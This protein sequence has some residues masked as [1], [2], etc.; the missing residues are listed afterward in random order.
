MSAETPK[1]LADVKAFGYRVA[2]ERRDSAPEAPPAFFVIGAPRSGSTSLCSTLKR[3]PRISFSFPKETH[4]LHRSRGMRSLAQWRSEYLDRYHGT[5]GPQHQAVGDGSVSYLYALETVERAME[6]D[7]RARFLMVLRNPVDMIQSWHLRLL[8]LLDE[9]EESFE[10]AWALQERRRQ[11]LDVPP[12]CRDP[13]ILQYGEIGCHALHVQRV[14]ELVGRE[15]C[16]VLLFDDLTSDPGATYRRTLAFLGVDDDGQTEFR[17]KRETMAF[18]STT[19]QRLVMNPPGWILRMIQSAS[20]R[21]LPRLK[22]LRK[23]LKRLNNRKA[24]RPRLEPDTVKMLRA[25]FAE[26]VATLSSLL[27]RDLGHWLDGDTV[28]DATGDSAMIGSGSTD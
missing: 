14:Y 27:G 13:R 21:D 12:K 10:S 5:L 25:H 7:P 6:F 17:R 1:T 18:R 26:D 19:I 23:S 20:V 9:D 8:Y 24:E 28:A 2:D 3:N 22:R 15:R 4:Y 11:G 16:L